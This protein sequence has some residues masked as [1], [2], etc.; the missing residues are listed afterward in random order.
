M[1]TFPLRNNLTAIKDQANCGACWAFATTAVLEYVMITYKNVSVQLSEQEL[2]DCNTA[3]MSCN[4]GWPSYAYDYV[5]AND[6]TI[7]DYY[8]Y[9]A[10]SNKCLKDRTPRIDNITERCE[11]KF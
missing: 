7:N 9:L 4:G 3:G 11:R 2:I 10:Y 6:L 8:Q 1:P 5:I